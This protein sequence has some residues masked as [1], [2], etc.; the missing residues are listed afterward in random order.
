MRYGIGYQAVAKIESLNGGMALDERLP[1]DGFDAGGVGRSVAALPMPETPTFLSRLRPRFQIHVFDQVPSTNQ[2]LWDMVD[3]KAGTVAIAHR[4][5]AG[6]GQR[7][8]QWIS[9]PGGVYLSLM[10]EPDWPADQ[11]AQLTLCTAWG[12][13]SQFRHLGI[14]ADIKW[15]NDIVVAG[16]KLGGILSESKLDQGIITRAV[17]G[18][19]INVH[20]PVPATG[21]TWQD[22]T[23]TN[24]NYSASPLKKVAAAVLLGIWRGV[25]YRNYTDGKTFIDAYQSLLTNLNMPVILEGQTL[26]VVGVTETG[27]LTL[28]LASQDSALTGQP[29]DQLVHIKSGEFSLGYPQTTTS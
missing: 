20:N 24:D 5:T 25:F 21:I 11:S 22:L 16:R 27:H 26:K 28:K 7:G 15:P 17:I 4:Q 9:P 3:A 19:G 14:P 18:V 12:I 10:L 8:K 23:Q 1:F 29:I 6:K 13:V 2:T